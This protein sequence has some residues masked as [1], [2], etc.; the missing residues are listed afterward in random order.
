MM[1]ISISLNSKQL[2]RLKLFQNVLL[3]LVF[4]CVEHRLGLSP[5]GGYFAAYIVQ[6]KCLDH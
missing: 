3:K 2:A 5:L 1:C 4:Y 6:R